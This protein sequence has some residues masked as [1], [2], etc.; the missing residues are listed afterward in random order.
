MG[1]L[2]TFYPSLSPSRANHYLVILF[3]FYSYQK[4]KKAFK[5]NFKRSSART[6]RRNNE[7]M[8]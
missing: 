2:H 3:L 4:Y 1:E 5:A 6:I 8:A 7:A